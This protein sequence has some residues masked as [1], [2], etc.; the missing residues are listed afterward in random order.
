MPASPMKGKRAVAGVVKKKVKKE[1]GPPPE[2]E[3]P[4]PGWL[5]SAATASWNEPLQQ[6]QQPAPSGN[7]YAFVISP[8]DSGARGGGPSTP[9]T[10]RGLPFHRGP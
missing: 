4:P 7:P 9:A 2:V 6:R 1:E 8:S 3:M 5:V 10:A